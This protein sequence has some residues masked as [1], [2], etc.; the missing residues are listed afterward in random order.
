MKSV[1]SDSAKVYEK[2]NLFFRRW[3]HFAMMI[4]CCLLQTLGQKET[5][6]MCATR[7]YYSAEVW[8]DLD[9]LLGFAQ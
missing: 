6:G 1:L 9:N 2:Q 3:A 7:L 5:S 8:Q 4:V